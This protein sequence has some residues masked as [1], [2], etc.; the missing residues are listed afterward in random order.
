MKKVLPVLVLLSFLA[1]LLVP[2]IASAQQAPAEC[3]KLKRSFTDVI[4]G[5]A[6]SDGAVVGPRIMTTDE[7]SA[8]EVIAAGVTDKWGACCT[9]NTVHSV[10]DWIFVGII[11]AVIIFVL[12]GAMTILGAG[13]DPEAVGKGRNYIMYAAIGLV[14]AFLARA[15]PSIVSLVM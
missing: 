12:L 10:I 1:V 4:G 7:C 9:L 11:V 5:T 6:C 13:G 2:V 14:V 3:C 15:V 8:G